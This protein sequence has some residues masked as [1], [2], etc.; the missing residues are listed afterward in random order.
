VYEASGTVPGWLL[1]SSGT[2][3]YAMSAWDGALRV[4]TTTAGAVAGWSGQPA[5]SA[6]YVLE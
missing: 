5:Q 4:A 6:V 2:A 3:Q 1:G